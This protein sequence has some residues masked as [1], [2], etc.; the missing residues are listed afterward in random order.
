M[1]RLRKSLLGLATSALAILPLSAPVWADIA[2]GLEALNSEDV[3]TALGEFQKAFEA[4]DGEGAFYLGRMLERGVGGEP[5]LPQ[6][7]ALYEEAVKATTP[8]AQAKNRLGLLYLEG[9]AVLQDYEEGAR[10]VCESAEAGD[11]NGQFNCALVLL[12]GQGVAVDAEKAISFAEMSAEQGNVGAKNLL[13]QSY[14]TGTG[15]KA[16]DTK[17]LEYFQQTAAVGN[18][19]GL[20]SLG[21][22][23]ALGIG[24]DRDLVK[25]HAFFNLAA[26]RRHPEALQARQA[27]E[28]QL[29][30]DDVVAAQ[31]F[32]RA[33]RPLEEE[34]KPA[35]DN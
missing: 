18:P 27:V 26:A 7:V 3:Q 32:A 20:F 28:E 31:R 16:D 2:K 35:S 1:Q 21:Q 22:A 11:Q 9:T 13:G 8:S 15:V 5:N 29:S 10:L 6:A 33:W 4:G 30:K 17:A 19:V 23:Y 14:V 12:D 24:L 25:A 34:A